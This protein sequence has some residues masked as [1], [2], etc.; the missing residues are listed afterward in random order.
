MWYD[1]QFLRL[2]DTFAKNRQTW[3]K[4]YSFSRFT[5]LEKKISK[6]EKLW[7]TEAPGLNVLRFLCFNFFPHKS[8]KREQLA[9]FFFIF[10][11]F[12]YFWQMCSSDVKID[13]RTTH[14]FIW[15]LKHYYCCMC[16]LNVVHISN[17]HILSSV[18][19][20]S[21]YNIK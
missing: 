21:I 10:C 16:E 14:N 8:V 3:Q 9:D 2:R 11:M 1:H 20:N 13:G 7:N 5:N 15:Y 18:V 17:I 4:M 12:V 19:N 6:T